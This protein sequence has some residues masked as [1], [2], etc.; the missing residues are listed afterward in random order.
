MWDIGTSN[1]VYRNRSCIGNTFFSPNA[2]SKVG[3]LPIHEMVF[4][5]IFIRVR[6]ASTIPFFHEND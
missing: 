6:T 5:F 4:F 1:C 3:V 2:I